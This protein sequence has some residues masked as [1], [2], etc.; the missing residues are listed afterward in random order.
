MAESKTGWVKWVVGGVVGLGVVAAGG[1]YVISTTNSAK[2]K[3]AELDAQAKANAAALA[4]AEAKAQAA[5]ADAASQLAKAQAAAKAETADAE[6]PKT[7]AKPA[8]DPFSA[9]LG[10]ASTVFTAI[11][12]VDGIKSFIQGFAQA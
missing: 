4:K 11:G 1:Y 7:E 9:F 10:T 3:A 6:K 2:A 12:G 8:Q 5:Q